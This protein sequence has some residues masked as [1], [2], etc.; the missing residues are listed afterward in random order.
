MNEEQRKKKNEEAVERYHFYKSKGICVQCGQEKAAKGKTKCLNCLDI[1]SVRQ[2]LTRSKWTDEEKN[3]TYLKKNQYLKKQYQE[4]K[5]AG[6]CPKCRKHK[7]EAGY[8]MCK[9][10][11]VKAS[12]R[13][14]KRRREK[15]ILPRELFGDGKHCFYCGKEVQDE[16]ACKSCKQKVLKGLKKAIEVS[17]NSTSPEHWHITNNKFFNCKGEIKN[18]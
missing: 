4:C 3:A 8:V 2:M 13:Q 16:R 6:L 5:E 9:Y 15:G 11:R 7:P 12:K 17:K 1:D 10:C 18:D 14:E